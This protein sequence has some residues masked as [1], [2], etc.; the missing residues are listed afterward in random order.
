MEQEN[1]KWFNNGFAIV[2]LNLGVFSVYS[3][4][5]VYPGRNIVGGMLDIIFLLIHF[6]I[7]VTFGSTSKRWVW[8]LSGFIILTIGF[9]I[10][11]NYDYVHGD[12][13]NGK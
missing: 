6:L 8:I 5:L 7:C 11:G 4:V 1:K 13:P 10:C 12:M 9:S 2:G 3:L